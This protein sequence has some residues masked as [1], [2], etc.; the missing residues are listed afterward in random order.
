M[1]S[2]LYVDDEPALLEIGR[3]Y[4]EKFTGASVD[5]SP[6]SVSAVTLMHE[7]RY[8]AVISDYQMPEMDGITLL[9]YVRAHF[10]DLP[11]ILF[12]GRGREEVVIEALNNGA[13]FYVQKGGDANAQFIEL[14]HKIMNAV[15]K[16]RAKEALRNAEQ[17]RADLID[18]LPDATFAVNTEGQVIAWNKAME[19][20]TGV[21]AAKI[22]GKGDYEYSLAIYGTRRPALL[23]LV[24][25]P[26]ADLTRWNYTLV[27]REGSALV[28]ETTMHRSDG[29]VRTLVGKASALYDNKGVIVGVIELLRD[30][31]EKKEAE[32]S[33]LE[34]AA[35]F[36]SLVQA[37]SDGIVI[38]DEG[39]NFIEWNEA[40][41]E[42]TGIP[43]SS[44][45]GRPFS[46]IMVRFMVP[47]HRTPERI[48][49][50]RK[51]VDNALKTGESPLFS[52]L[53]EV[54]IR[55]PNGSNRTIQQRVFPIRTSA[56]FRIGSITRD[57]TS[58][59]RA[60]DALQQA[61]RKLNLMAS[62]TRHDILNLITAL[63]GYLSLSRDRANDPT[64]EEYLKNGETIT[65]TIEHHITF[66]GDY[67]SVGVKAPQW[68]GLRTVI[69]AAKGSLLPDTVGIE[70]DVTDIEVYADPLFARV[71]FNLFDNALRYGG[72]QLTT[73]RVTTRVTPHALVIAC[74][75]DGVGIPAGEK[76][77]IFECGVGQHTG[78]GLFLTREIL[79]ITGITIAET[80]GT[81][82]GARFEITV[83]EGIFRHAVNGRPSSNP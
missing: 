34:S 51:A 45:L 72:S 4:L 6:S 38:A 48:D 41:A 47:E 12:T 22:L 46:E 9:K 81:G 16:R 75:D 60:E 10:S 68:F 82:E 77:A 56:G 2:L 26:D 76:E 39:G 14:A 29:M 27:R 28:A 63:K 21:P 78:L 42:I 49:H 57:I 62:I 13:D 19:C 53:L 11:F 83:P 73:I 80:S 23:D 37:S 54:D 24:S 31:T 17:Y 74:C 3:I 35:K 70:S 71:F 8:D 59:R 33:L 43:A 7:R 25:L 61:N 55:H 66:T 67:Q 32:R 69:L 5:V 20:L 36:S 50:I 58:R 64:L 15:E 40:E 30:I 79:A 1:I 18:F 44:A 52:Q 65:R